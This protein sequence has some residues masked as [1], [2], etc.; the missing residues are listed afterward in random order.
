M[1]YWREKVVIVTGGSRGFGQALARS[2]AGAGAS[3]VLAA[4]G[5]QQLDAAADEVRRRG[6]QAL[7]VSTDVTDQ[8]QVEALIA[9]TIERFGRIDALVNN[10]GHSP[11]GE[12]ARTSAEDFGELMELNLLGA[13]RCTQAALPH[14]LSARGH[15]V[16]IGSLASKVAARWGG[17][18]AATKFALAAYSQQLRLELEDDGLHV[19]LVC[20]GPIAGD[21]PRERSEEELAGLPSSARQPGSGVRMK[22]LDPRRTA[23]EVLRACE[24]RR[25]EL[26]IPSRA[27]LLFVLSALSP[28]WGDWLV[29]KMTDTAPREGE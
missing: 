15:V 17:A 29:R 12:L 7:A 23:A 5:G 3:V 21:E 25:R 26:V 28:T 2:F 24:R 16:N 9:A 10:A 6:G 19:L 1:S 27:R 13:V 14:L 18:Y 11:R 8:S 22:R 20:P 4:R